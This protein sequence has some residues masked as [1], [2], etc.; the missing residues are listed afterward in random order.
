MDFITILHNA[1]TMHKKGIAKHHIPHFQNFLLV[2]FLSR[3]GAARGKNGEPAGAR[4]HLIIKI[5]HEH[6]V[7]LDFFMRIQH[8]VVMDIT[9]EQ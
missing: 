6:K 8:E 9:N 4:S 1:E 5:W 7:P 3:S 2:G